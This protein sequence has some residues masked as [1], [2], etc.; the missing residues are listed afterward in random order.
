[1]TTR[2]FPVRIS[3]VT[4]TEMERPGRKRRIHSGAVRGKQPGF[5]FDPK[6]TQMAVVAG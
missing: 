4:R 1:M 6:M 2:A 3:K 5:V